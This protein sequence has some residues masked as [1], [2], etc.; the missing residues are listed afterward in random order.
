MIPFP[1]QAGQ[2]GLGAGVA[3]VPSEWT[4]DNLASKPRIWFNDSSAVTDAGSG[5][6][7]QWNDINTATSASDALQATSANRPLIVTGAQNGRRVITADG[8]TDFMSIARVNLFTNV[9]AGWCFAVFKRTALDG[10]SVTRTLFQVQTP[11]SDVNRFIF[12][13]GLSN[14]GNDG[15]G[16]GVRRLDA[17]S[18]S[19]LAAS[20]LTDTNYHLFLATM[21]WANRTGTLYLDGA[22]VAQNTTLT[23]AGSTSATNS[24]T[25]HSL[26]A[27]PLGGHSN[28]SLAEFFVGLTLPSSPEIDRLFG[29]AAHRWGLTGNLDSGHPYKTSPPTV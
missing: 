14:A 10:A 13:A 8:T 6:C 20:S 22:Q 19:I 21:D 27:R 18:A 26:F 1:F 11:T 15:W 24:F 16:I 9:S 12:F 23:S 7:S 4:P 5:A 28:V 25:D 29:Y 3:T 2:F 17:D